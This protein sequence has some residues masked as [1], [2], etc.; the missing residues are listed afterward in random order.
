MSVD[1]LHRLWPLARSNPFF[2]RL[3]ANQPTLMMATR[4]SRTTE[5]VRIA[6]ATG[7]HAIMLDL[8]HSANS[9]ET[10]WEMCGAAG[11]L[12]LPRLSGSPSAIT[13]A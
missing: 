6:K 4:S 13:A 5:I 7:N 12:G 11:D 9:M 10:A 8:E 3:R 2:D 1:Y